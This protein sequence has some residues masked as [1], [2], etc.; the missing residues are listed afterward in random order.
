MVKHLETIKGHILDV[1]NHV[2]LYFAVQTSSL[3]H[4]REVK[5]KA[6]G[7]KQRAK[8]R[9]EDMIKVKKAINFR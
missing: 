1:L 2:I 8:Q 6:Q 5:S 3:D 7:N 4:S 9:L